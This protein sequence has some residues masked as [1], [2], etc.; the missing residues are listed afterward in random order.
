MHSE[1]TLNHALVSKTSHLNIAQPRLNNK[2]IGRKQKRISKG[3]NKEQSQRTI[4]QHEHAYNPQLHS[5]G[6]LLTLISRSLSTGCRQMGHLF[7]WNLKTLAHPLHIHCT[8]RKREREKGDQ[9]RHLDWPVTFVSKGFVEGERKVKN[10]VLKLTK[11]H[12]WWE[13]HM[14][15]SLLNPNKQHQINNSIIHIISGRVEYSRLS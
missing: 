1:P 9:N 3:K 10:S 13:C 5:S 15:M 4:I 11:T 14:M 7:V 8:M 6:A 12:W 2:H